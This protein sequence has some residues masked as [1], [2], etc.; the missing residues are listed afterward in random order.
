MYSSLHHRY[1]FTAWVG[2]ECVYLILLSWDPRLESHI[3][4]TIPSDTGMTTA[5][6]VSYIIFSVI[7]LPVIWI[8]PHRLEMFFRFAC[9]I[10]LVF[11]LVLLIW[12]LVTMGPTGFGDTITS[13][14]PL[15][16][17]GGP[18]S[19]AWLMVYGI[20]ST[21]GSIA[22]GILNQ[23][24]Y[25]RFATQPKHAI[26]GQ[27]VS[28][29]FYGIF[30]SLI[31]ILVT[32]ATQDRFGGE[33]IWNP[34]TLF[35]Q[36]LAQNETAGTR[37]ACFFAG[38]CLVISQI[39]VNVPG[40]ALAGGF[41]LA[42]TFPRYL[43]IR[44]GAYLT[45]IFSVIVNPWRLVNTA[46]TFLTVLSSYSVFLA[47]MT[48]LMISSYLV[49]NKRKIDVDDLYRGDSESIYC[50]TDHEK[51]LVGV[52]PCMPG[53]VAAV[54]TSVTVSPGA[55]ELY[56]M[57]YVYGLLSSGLVYAVLHRVFPAKALDSFV[58]TAPSAKELQEFHL[59]KWDVTL[60]ETPNVVDV[61]SGHGDAS[62]VAGHSPPGNAGQ[63]ASH[64]PAVA[65]PITSSRLG[66]RG[67]W[68]L[69][70]NENRT[71]HS[72]GP[73]A[74][75]DTY[76][77]DSIPSGVMSSPDDVDADM[78]QVY[79]G[80][81]YPWDPP[82]H[83]CL[84]Q[85][86]FAPHDNAA[87]Q[88]AS[89]AIEGLVGPYG[90][91]LVRLYFK[92]VHPVLPILSKGRFLRQY[93]SDKTK[94]P[95]SLRGAVYALASVFEK[96]DPSLKGP[97]PFQQHQLADYATDSLQ[98]ELDSPNLAKLQA[99]LL[100][101]HVKPNHVDSIEHPRTWT[102][103][104]EAV[105]IAQMIGLHQD[106]ERWSLAPWEKRLR[107]KLWWVTYVTDVWSA[108]CHGNPPH[109]YPASF[110]TSAIAME[111]LRS[112]EDLSED[113][114]IMVEPIS[115]RFHVS[116][117]ARFLELVKISKMVRDLIDYS[118]TTGSSNNELAPLHLAYHASQALLFR[119]L[120]SPATNEAK[121]DPSSS[122][123]RWFGTAVAKFQGFARF[124]EEV[125]A[126]DL[127]GFWGRHARAHTAVPFSESGDILGT[128]GLE[129]SSQ[130]Q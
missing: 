37:A 9:S 14:S 76:V 75:Q 25:S 82:V 89:N 61:L 107:R 71:A 40:N 7:S 38:L 85:D 2:G 50:H 102:S 123:C 115:A 23:N 3:P 117:G 59:G 105:A 77:L 28:F 66:A 64:D 104:A 60:A 65:S 12:A 95:A 21:I 83:F 41:D 99:S 63:N 46:T 84:L 24:D 118:L 56:Y 18:D 124:M 112:D 92:H 120:M 67:L 10:T 96:K 69:E 119:A 5:Q 111:D 1:G 103:T 80:T 43:N 22:A 34:P 55:T 17:T 108:V 27:A 42:A 51:W 91:I 130:S 68:T 44:R 98:R 35:A 81:K 125:T 70:D 126:E 31:G 114:Q 121:S 116:T 97:F 54:D 30:S 15:P 88:T 8:R 93:A 106:P 4:N 33:A 86:E 62:L 20:V 73:A 32:A 48:G 87:K 74:E 45:A 127:Q 49:V 79:A 78:I 128:G 129:P 57:S 94:L 72:M 39:G 16:N 47:P 19:M 26:L 58:K 113:L 11:F 13:G 29:P 90:P 36:L 110:N 100:L 6:F 101:L 109:I 122:L 53:F 52:V